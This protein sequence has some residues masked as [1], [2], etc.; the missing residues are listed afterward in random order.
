M[1]ILY[2]TLWPDIPVA[3]GLALFPGYDKLIHAIMMGGMAAAIWFDYRRSGGRI[4]TKCIVNVA[5]AVTIFAA[6]DESIQHLISP[7]RTLDIFD[8]LAG[9]GGIVIASFT[10]PPVINRIFR[11]R[12]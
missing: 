7:S 5:I 4:T 6:L 1:V 9:V 2:A 3:E 11:K 12:R 10:A 8:F